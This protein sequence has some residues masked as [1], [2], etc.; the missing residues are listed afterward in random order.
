M[1]Y[2]KMSRKSEVNEEKRV[3]VEKVVVKKK[4]KKRER[5]KKS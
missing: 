1:E 5:K 4:E 2:R 3:K